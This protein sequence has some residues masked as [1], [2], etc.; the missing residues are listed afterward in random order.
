MESLKKTN[1]QEYTDNEAVNF[2]L[3]IFAYLELL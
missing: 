1:Q 2:S 3:D